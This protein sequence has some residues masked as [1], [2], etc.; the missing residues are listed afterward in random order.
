[1]TTKTQTD[2]SYYRAFVSVRMAGC[3]RSPSARARTWWIAVFDNTPAVIGLAV[4]PACMAG[5]FAR[6]L[7]DSLRG[8][9]GSGGMPGPGVALPPFHVAG[10]SRGSGKCGPRLGDVGGGRWGFIRV[11]HHGLLRLASTP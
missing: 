1:M 6:S 9:G 10:G 11:G 2:K 7:V 8:R 5:P 3:R 4:G